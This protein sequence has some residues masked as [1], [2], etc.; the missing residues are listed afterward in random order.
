MCVYGHV[1]VWACVCMCV[2]GMCVCMHICVC[3][4]AI[5]CTVS[6]LYNNLL[7]VRANFG[8]S[9]PSSNWLPPSLQKVS[10]L[11]KHIFLQKIKFYTHHHRP[12]TSNAFQLKMF[13]TTTRALPISHVVSCFNGVMYR[14]SGVQ[15][16]N[17]DRKGSRESPLW[18]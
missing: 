17:L 10:S 1:C 12:V 18:P 5:D 8:N 6:V 9:I 7:L 11:D 13:P 14:F 15:D 4:V 3:G 16:L 2:C